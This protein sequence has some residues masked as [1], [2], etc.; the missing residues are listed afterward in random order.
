[1][2]VL[3][4]IV[5]VL[6][7]ITH[8]PSQ[9]TVESGSTRAVAGIKLCEEHCQNVS[10]GNESGGA[11]RFLATLTVVIEGTTF[12]VPPMMINDLAEPANIAIHGQGTATSIEVKGGD[13]AGAYTA[14][15][16]FPSCSVSRKV[17]GEMCDEIYETRLFTNRLWFDGILDCRAGIE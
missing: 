8:S 16:S 3:T 4:G 2:K 10:W 6:T 12:E 1:M 15:F 5:S 17:C 14:V 9:L 11:K 7:L 13:G